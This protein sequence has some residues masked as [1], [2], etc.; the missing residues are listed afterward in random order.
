MEEKNKREREREDKPNWKEKLKGG[1]FKKECNMSP[2][3]RE[4]RTTRK[5]LGWGRGQG[6]FESS[7]HECCSSV[8]EGGR[9][10]KSVSVQ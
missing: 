4:L 7:G 2:S 9:G 3:A 10:K 1:G 6:R 8:E 5:S